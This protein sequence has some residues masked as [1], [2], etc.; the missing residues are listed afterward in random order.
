MAR[1][2]NSPEHKAQSK[3]QRQRHNENLIHRY[4]DGDRT[5]HKTIFGT[6]KPK[7]G[8]II[9]SIEGPRFAY[10]DRPLP[11]ATKT[12]MHQE[13]IDARHSAIE[14]NRRLKV[15]VAVGASLA[16]AGIFL[17]IYEPGIL[18]QPVIERTDQTTNETTPVISEG[19][20]VGSILVVAGLATSGVAI[21]ALRR[22]DSGRE[23]SLRMPDPE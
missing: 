20:R 8:L 7:K 18:D 11:R 21:L 4:N 12:V 10:T 2:L 22:N 5:L 14:L 17:S 16:S 6:I 1:L 23:L 15:G 13:Q 9:R 3:A 19:D